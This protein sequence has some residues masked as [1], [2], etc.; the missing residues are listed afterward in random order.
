MLFIQLR[1]FYPSVFAVAYPRRDIVSLRVFSNNF[2][3]NKAKLVVNT[4]GNIESNRCQ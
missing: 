1:A 2:L 4:Y 3:P